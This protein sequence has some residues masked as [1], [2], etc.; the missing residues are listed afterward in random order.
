MSRRSSFGYSSYGSHS[1]RSG[2][3]NSR[4]N[5][6]NRRK[7]KIVI[8]IIVVLLVLAAAAFCIWFFLLNKGEEKTQTDESSVVS[9]TSQ[10]PEESSKPEESSEESSEQESSKPDLVG[11]KDNNVF[12]YDKQG[13]EMFYGTEERAKDYAAVVSSVKKAVGKDV[14][15]YNMVV[16]THAAFGL[17]DKYLAEM[18]DEKANIEKIYSSYTEDVIPVDVYSAEDKHKNEYTYFK[19]DSNWTGLGAYYAYQEFC[20]AS[21]SKAVDI[22]SL[23]KGNISGFAGSLFVATKTEENPSGNK[24]LA[25]NRDT[26]IYYN[27]GGIASCTLLENGT[28]E[29]KEVDMIATF[30][31]GSNAYSAFIWGNNPYMSVKTTQKTGKKLCI[32][33]DSYGCALAPFTTANYD[34]V[35]I[36]DPRYYSGN[37]ADYIKKNKFT[38]VLIINSVMNANTEV[39]LSEIQSIIK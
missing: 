35:Y 4:R 30:A 8:S 17:P 34:E 24:E 1:Y 9:E 3:Y 36:V 10:E 37:V 31:E 19:T 26:V 18:N 27:M 11:Y 15:V 16:P 29:E 5:R 2:G 23:S 39:R 33:K 12:I 20:K 38:D 32:I 28:T 14:T 22:N 7:K 21:K 25:Q 13:Y 6:N